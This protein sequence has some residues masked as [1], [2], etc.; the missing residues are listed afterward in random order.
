MSRPR[1]YLSDLRASRKISLDNSTSSTARAMT[2]APTILDSKRIASPRAS[3]D[4]ARRNGLVSDFK[5]ARTC[6]VNAGFAA[7]SRPISAPSAV[8]RQPAEGVSLCS[9]SFE[10]KWL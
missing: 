10:S 6:S 4:F 7:G 9:A 1:V 5:T 2:T 8:M 3:R